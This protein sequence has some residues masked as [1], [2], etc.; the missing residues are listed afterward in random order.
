MTPLAKV[1]LC[2]ATGDSLP[3]NS[4]KISPYNTTYSKMTLPAANFG[5]D[6]FQNMGSTHNENVAFLKKKIVHIPR[7]Y[8]VAISIVV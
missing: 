5:P 7:I 6:C 4:G 8:Q 1:L 2:G 3:Y